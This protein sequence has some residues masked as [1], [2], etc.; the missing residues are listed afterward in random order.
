MSSNNLKFSS[1]DMKKINSYPNCKSGE[2]IKNPMISQE[3]GKEVKDLCKTKLSHNIT[4]ALFIYLGSF[5]NLCVTTALVQWHFS[6]VYSID[7][8][9]KDISN[10]SCNDL[11]W[12]RSLLRSIRIK[13]MGSIQ[14]YFLAMNLQLQQSNELF[15]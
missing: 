15:K 12:V 2:S 9:C 8:F 6:Q 10:A 14:W 13:Y 4:I 7:S 11:G 1:G 3:R 5:V